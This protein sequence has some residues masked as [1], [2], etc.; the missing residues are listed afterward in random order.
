MSDRRVLVNEKAV[1]LTLKPEPV[2]S[3]GFYIG[4]VQDKLTLGELSDIAR[5][6][7]DFVREHDHKS[8]IP[9]T[10]PNDLL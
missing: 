1:E 4:I 6:I 5:I 7:Q 2:K 3:N 8:D 9:W 10:T